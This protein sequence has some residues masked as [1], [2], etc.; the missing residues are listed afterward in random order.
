MAL[1]PS[2][3]A[4]LAEL[5]HR[6]AELQRSHDALLASVTRRG[7]ASSVAVVADQ[8][9]YNGVLENSTCMEP[10]HP[11]AIVSRTE[12]GNVDVRVPRIAVCAQS[13]RDAWR[14]VL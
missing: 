13:Q 6:H 3:E 11:R 12:E 10:D 5:M 8:G 7:A 14:A 9:M 1:N 4:Q 2:V